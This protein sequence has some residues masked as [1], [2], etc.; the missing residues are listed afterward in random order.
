MYYYFFKLLF[1]EYLNVHIPIEEQSFFFVKIWLIFFCLFCFF[2]VLFLRNVL[3]LWVNWAN[4]IWSYNL[5]WNL[6]GFLQNC[7]DEY[8][9]TLQFLSLVRAAI[10]EIHSI[11]ILPGLFNSKIN[12]NQN[13]HHY[14]IIPRRFSFRFQLFRLR[15]LFI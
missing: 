10:R 15:R 1:R 4:R 8:G 11:N 2:F 14:S 12:F 6:F 3:S 9:L 5:L 13:A 7:I